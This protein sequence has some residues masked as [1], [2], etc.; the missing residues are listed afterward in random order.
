MPAHQKIQSNLIDVSEAAIQS[1]LMVLVNQIEAH[2]GKPAILAPSPA[3]ERRY[4]VG[5]RIERNARQILAWG[6]V[7][8]ASEVIAKVDAV[9][10]ERDGQPPREIKIGSFKLSGLHDLAVA[11]RLALD[12]HV[13]QLALGIDRRIDRE[14]AGFR[15]HQRVAVRCGLG[16]R[17][18]AGDVGGATLVLDDDLLAPVLGKLLAEG[19]RHHIGDA[20]GRRGDDQRDRPGRI[21]LC[22]RADK[23]PGQ[24]QQHAKKPHAEIPHGTS[25]PEC[26]YSAAPWLNRCAPWLRVPPST[27]SACPP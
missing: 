23:K 12:T 5:G 6:R 9:T 25:S 27:I 3:F 7:I 22:L 19:A 1:E 14:G 21:G 10:V 4:R 18:R 16:H 17:A 26:R 20:A 15:D 11:D 2:A 24:R 13:G 8:P